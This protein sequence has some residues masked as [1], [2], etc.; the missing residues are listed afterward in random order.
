MK[1]VMM[2]LG[3]LIVICVVVTLC[4][5]VYPVNAQN[6][7]NT[8]DLNRWAI[9]N[10]M[11]IDL[12]EDDFSLW[13]QSKKYKSFA[14]TH[15]IEAKM[16]GVLKLGEIETGITGFEYRAMVECRQDKPD[17]ILWVQFI[18]K[19]KVGNQFDNQADFAAYIIVFKDGRLPIL[20]RKSLMV[21]INDIVSYCMRNGLEVKEFMHTAP[22]VHIKQ[23]PKQK[24]NADLPVL[25]DKYPGTVN[26][27]TS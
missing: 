22:K 24:I 1:K 4:L 14:E 26:V 11:W 12:S 5:N 10:I 2:Y 27:L 8:K 19:V 9:T 6:P 21:A 17:Y 25:Q 7:A 18:D 16:L 13:A 23:I 3:T 20:T 15:H